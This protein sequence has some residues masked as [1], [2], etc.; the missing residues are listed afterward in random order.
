MNAFS[1]KLS[2]VA[3]L[4]VIAF[5][6]AQTVEKDKRLCYY[7]FQGGE[8][9]YVVEI[10]KLCP[11]TLDMEVDQEPIDCEYLEPGCGY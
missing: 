4:L 7:N 10:T 1:K 5:L 8:F 11:I 6:T 9:L 2:A 3:P